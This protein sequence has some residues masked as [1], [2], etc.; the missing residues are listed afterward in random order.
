LAVNG[1]QQQ[2]SATEKQ[3]KKPEAVDPQ[4]SPDVLLIPSDLKTFAMGVHGVLCVNPGRM[5]RGNN[6]G[7]YCALTVHPLDMKDAERRQ[8]EAHS[9]EAEKR[10]E[11]KQAL[12]DAEEAAA[13]DPSS[14]AAVVTATAAVAA[15]VPVVPTPAPTSH[16]DGALLHYVL[17]RTRAELIRI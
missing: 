15:S 4:V 3:S 6:G 11:A 1:D 9:A 8:R 13:A 14:A 16:K 7:Q 5:A 12:E 10:V 17:D 2:G